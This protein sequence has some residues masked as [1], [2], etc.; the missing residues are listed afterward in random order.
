MQQLLP[1]VAG[2]E[3]IDF[4]LV[5]PSSCAHSSVIFHKDTD[6]LKDRQA[7]VKGGLQ[8]FGMN[9][10]PFLGFLQL[11]YFGHPTTDDG[12]KTKKGTDYCY[13]KV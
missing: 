7:V 11:Y 10:L 2:P 13:P 1:Y 5:L 3:Q 4:Q 12:Y 8:S 6:Q 9:R